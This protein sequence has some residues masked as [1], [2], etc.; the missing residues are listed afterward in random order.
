MQKCY[1]LKLRMFDEEK[2]KSSFKI[3]CYN[4]DEIREDIENLRKKL[5]DLELKIN[6]FFTTGKN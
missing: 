2:I 1:I 3:L 5:N 6:N 4:L